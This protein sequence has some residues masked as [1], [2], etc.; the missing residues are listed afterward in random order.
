M[1]YCKK[2]GHTNLA[3]LASSKRPLFWMIVAIAAA[4]SVLR[5]RATFA[6]A[7]GR[8]A[9]TFLQLCFHVRIMYGAS[10][11]FC[12][13]SVKDGKASGSMTCGVCFFCFV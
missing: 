2:R 8:F 7:L 12:V 3:G 10:Q 5:E 6:T 4:C 11:S 1:R 13:K 9:R